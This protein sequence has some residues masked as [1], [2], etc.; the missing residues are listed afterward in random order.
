MHAGSGK[1]PLAYSYLIVSPDE[2][3]YDSLG[4]E[5]KIPQWFYA[6]MRAT[7]GN[8]G[9]KSARAAIDARS[10]ALPPFNLA[11]GKTIPRYSGVSYFA[12]KAKLFGDDHDFQIALFPAMLD[13]GILPAPLCR[14]FV[15]NC[16]AASLLRR[17]VF[18]LTRY[19]DA[20]LLPVH[21]G[22]MR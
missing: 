22:V 20:A 13:A 4:H 7:L 10:Q 2:L 14:G 21:D 17:E 8:A 16:E 5:K 11:S 15:A 1:L 12:A 6:A 3:H 9:A 18:A 19:D